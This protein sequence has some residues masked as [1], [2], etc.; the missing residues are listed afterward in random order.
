MKPATLN[1]QPRTAKAI[2]QRNV[3][4]I[5]HSR[6][7]VECLLIQL[8]AKRE[9]HRDAKNAKQRREN[10]GR[11]LSVKPLRSLRRCVYV[12]GGFPILAANWVSKVEF[13]PVA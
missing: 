11:K 5:G 4:L 13:F 10:I 9:K 6:L 7:N 8:V 12:R 2:F 3:R 1:L